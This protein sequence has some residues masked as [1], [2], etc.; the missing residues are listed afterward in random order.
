MR[1]AKRRLIARP[2]IKTGAIIVFQAPAQNWRDKVR[3]MIA[4]Q[5][6]APA[7]DD[8]PTAKNQA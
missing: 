3:A 8:G 2:T 5:S 4:A 7:K 6:E 1:A